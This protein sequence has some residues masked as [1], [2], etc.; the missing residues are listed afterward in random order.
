[1]RQALLV[2]GAAD[3]SGGLQEMC[4]ALLAPV[5]RRNR[6]CMSSEQHTP[7]A[8]SSA[9]AC[10]GKKARVVLVEMFWLISFYIDGCIVKDKMN[11][12][13]SEPPDA[14]AP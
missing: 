6:F 14:Y 2:P 13:S 9:S 3:A 8:P 10:G 5:H 4:Q 11:I 12:L 7:N 1:M